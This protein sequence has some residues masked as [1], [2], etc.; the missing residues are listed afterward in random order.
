MDKPEIE[1]KL[2]GIVREILGDDRMAINPEKSLMVEYGLDSL[3]LI[4]FSFTAE[5]M[6]HVKIGADELKG[7]AKDRM[8]EEEMLDEKGNL[9]P[10]ALQALKES[11][12][13]I[14]PENFRYG[15]RQEDIPT[16]LNI[17]VFTRIV[18]E[19]MQGVANGSSAER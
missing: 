8:T 7:R 4:D 16:L 14:P 10:T 15:L 3:D 12:P 2:I 13:E 11:I 19:Q 1:E 6:F 9:S 5:E 18:L 17:R